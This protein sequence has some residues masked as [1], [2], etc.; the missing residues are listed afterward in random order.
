MIDEKDPDGKNIRVGFSLKY[1][2]EALESL[3]SN[4]VE[5]MFSNNRGVCKI[6]PHLEEGQE[7]KPGRAVEIVLPITI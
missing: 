3:N 7:P 2:I 1:L 6:E 4:R 5:M